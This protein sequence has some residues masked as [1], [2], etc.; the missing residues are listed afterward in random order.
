MTPTKPHFASTKFQL[1][2]SVQGMNRYTAP[3]QINFDK[4]RTKIFLIVLLSLSGFLF[5]TSC[6]KYEE[7]PL[8]SFRTV[9]GRLEG[10]W[11]IEK[12]LVNGIDSTQLYKD[13][14]G[15]NF[16]FYHPGTSDLLLNYLNFRTDFNTMGNSQSSYYTYTFNKNKTQINI[17]F[18]D[19]MNNLGPLGKDTNIW[20]PIP[21]AITKLST[22]HLWL[23]TTYDNKLYEYKYIKI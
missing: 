3:L 10:T 15:C 23:S 4:M 22:R 13:S 18:P 8:L 14:C 1:Q 21:F 6:K 7:G 12:Y 16:M 20:D 19:Y 9:N 17:C 11:E 2:H 5:I